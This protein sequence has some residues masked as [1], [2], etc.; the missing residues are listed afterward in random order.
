ME[1]FSLKTKLEAA[2]VEIAELREDRK[3]L[4]ER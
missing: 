4:V 2:E 1:V 3:E